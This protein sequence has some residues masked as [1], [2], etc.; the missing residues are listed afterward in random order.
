ML[1]LLGALGSAAIGAFGQWNTNRMQADMMQQQMGFQE[2][3]SNTA[4]QRARADMEAAG[5]N[6]MMMFNS[7][8]AAS[9]PAGAPASPMVKSGFDADAVQKAVSTAVQYA[10]S[11]AQ[12]DNIQADTNKKKAEV[13]TELARPHLVDAQTATTMDVGRRTAAEEKV[14]RARLPIVENEALTA[15][16][17]QKINS[18]A[19]R[20]LDQSSFT[21]SNVSKTLAPVSDIVWSAKGLKSLLPQGRRGT[22][23]TTD[24]YGNVTTKQFD[25]RYGTW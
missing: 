7:G 17:Q 19:R 16:N 9:T 5:L 8:S 13:V 14:T 11:Q 4:Y 18:T 20:I 3:M 24:E 1:P 23:S 15:A 21:G 12:I 25:E 22:S 6:P 10:T 2:R